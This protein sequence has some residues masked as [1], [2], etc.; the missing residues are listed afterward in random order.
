MDAA[1]PAGPRAAFGLIRSPTFGPY[2]VGNASSAS[3]TWCQN[4]AAQLPVLRLSHSA[5]LLGVLN[6]ANFIPVLALAPWAASAADRLDSRRLLIL[7]QALA[8]ILRAALAVLPWS[9]V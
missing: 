6:F 1:R 9:S 3:G 8:T 5:F 4:L 7:T 2:F